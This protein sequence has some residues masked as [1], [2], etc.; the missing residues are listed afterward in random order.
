MTYNDKKTRKIAIHK[1]KKKIDVH[2][3]DMVRCE[4]EHDLTLIHSYQKFKKKIVNRLERFCSN[5]K[6]LSIELL[7]AFVF[8]IKRSYLS[9]IDS[10]YRRNSRPTDR[11]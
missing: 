6:H 1:K 4:E 7:P 10:V 11:T 5:C 3:I 9:Q 8:T 2:W